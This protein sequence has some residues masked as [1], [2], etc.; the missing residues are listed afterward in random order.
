MS[1]S[2]RTLLSEIWRAKEGTALIE[3]TIVFPVILLLM[4][5]TV[6]FGMAFSDDATLGKSVRDAGRYL[7]SLPGTMF[8]SGCPAWA[9]QNATDLVVYG[10]FPVVTTG[11]DAD[12]SLISGWSSS[13]PDGSAGNNVT[14]SCTSTAISVSANAPYN[15][16]MLSVLFG[17]A[18]TLTLSAQ[19]NEVVVND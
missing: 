2:P 6:D 1:N 8:S 3:M 14:I 13:P 7:A 15:T 5:G 10:K 11:T 18:A 16:L 12:Q 9:Q 17:G 4:I 19:H